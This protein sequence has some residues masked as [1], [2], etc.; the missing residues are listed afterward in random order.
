MCIYCWR[1]TTPLT[2]LSID[3]IFSYEILNT[4][5]LIW[6][7]MTIYNLSLYV[8]FLTFFQFLHSEYKTLQSF[9]DLGSLNFFSKVLIIALFSMAGVP[10]FWGF[11]SKIFLFTLL[12]N[13]NFFILFPFFFILLFIGLY[14]YVQNIRF[15][16]ST[17]GAN[18][19]PIT[20][21]TCRNTPLYYYLT[22]T[23]LFFLTFGVYF[24][25]DLLLLV[26]WL[27]F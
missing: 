3:L 8:V 20:E 19:T 23:F 24:T 21:V 9:I 22:F 16:N 7:Y 2:T 13:S 12:A 4:L 25:E 18:F 14:F 6:S 27:L 26:Q 1:G 17:S 15:L 5:V 11:F 10:P